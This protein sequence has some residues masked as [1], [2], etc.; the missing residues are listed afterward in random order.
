MLIANEQTPKQQE[1]KIT[2]YFFS[3]FFPLSHYRQKHYIDKYKLHH[4]NAL[5]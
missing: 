3:F 1:K 5:S 2:G 4:T